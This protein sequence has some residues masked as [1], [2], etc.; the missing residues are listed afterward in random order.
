[1][2]YRHY[3]HIRLSGVRNAMSYSPPGGQWPVYP[4]NQP[5]QPY[6]SYQQPY[7]PYQQPYPYPYQPQPYPPY[8]PYQ[9]TPETQPNEG[10]LPTVPEGLAPGRYAR[11]VAGVLGVVCLIAVVLAALGPALTQR[12]QASVPSGWGKAYDG[13]IR[14]DGTWDTADDCS[15]KANGL[16][17]RANDSSSNLSCDFKPSERLDVLGQGFYIEAKVAPAASVTGA[18]TP[19]L[20]AGEGED[21]NAAFDQDGNYRLCAGTGAVCTYGSTVAWHSDGFVPNT[22]G[23]LFIPDDP[24]SVSGTIT[25][26]AN[27]QAVASRSGTLPPNSPLALGAEKG[28]E[29]LFTHVTLYL[30]STR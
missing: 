28:S 16:D 26:F 24:N 22:I 1:M 23:L 3:Q 10:P 7:P 25:L 9:P 17:V 11:V 20:V 30:A 15:L 18:Q 14:S 4:S 6:S 13:A 2:S 5:N 19:M 21:I 12:A 27:G 29:A 8:Q